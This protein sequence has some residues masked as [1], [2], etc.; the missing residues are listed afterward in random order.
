MNEI[1]ILH[2][3]FMYVQ[4]NTDYFDN[5]YQPVGFSICHFVLCEVGNEC[6]YIFG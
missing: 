5:N 3:N 1:D 4:I 6:F 2:I